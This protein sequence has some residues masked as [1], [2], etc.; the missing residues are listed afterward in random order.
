METNSVILQGDKIIIFSMSKKTLYL[1]AINKNKNKN[2][3]FMKINPDVSDINLKF[4]K[5]SYSFVIIKS[6]KL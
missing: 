1:K 6:V 4:N 5:K 2:I 3:L